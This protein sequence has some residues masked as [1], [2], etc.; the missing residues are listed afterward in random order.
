MHKQYAQ[1]LIFL[2]IKKYHLNIFSAN[3]CPVCSAAVRSV[4]LCRSCSLDLIIRPRTRPA[5]NSYHTRSH[6]YNR[7][8][9]YII[10]TPHDKCNKVLNSIDFQLVA[11][12]ML[13]MNTGNDETLHII[14]PHYIST[15]PTVLSIARL[16]TVDR[17]QLPR[18]SL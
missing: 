2:P 18:I 9:Y 15:V 14:I 13:H 4:V 16:R 10:S 1:P 8:I 12:I 3:V 11:H 7:Y 6:A 5:Q 17:Q